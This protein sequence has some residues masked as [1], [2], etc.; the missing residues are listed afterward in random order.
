MQ[1]RVDDYYAAFT[2]AVAK[3]RGVSLSDVRDGMG[4][5]RVLGA[6]MAVEQRM[7]DGVMTFDEV[8]R[9]MQR[10]AKANASGRNRIEEVRRSIALAAL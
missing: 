7:V 2:K 3:G 9:K 1:S 10:S 4:Q 6:D 5:G 8:L